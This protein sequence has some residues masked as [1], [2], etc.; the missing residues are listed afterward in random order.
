MVEQ[1]VQMI[2]VFSLTYLT[3]LFYHIRASAAIPRTGALAYGI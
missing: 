1:D 2:N 3:F